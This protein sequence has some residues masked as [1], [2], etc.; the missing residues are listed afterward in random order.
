MKIAQ[1]FIAVVLVLAAAC[2]ALVVPAQARLT[3]IPLDDEY[4]IFVIDTSGS[5]RRYQW[6]RLLA[7]VRE[8]LDSYPTVRGIQVISDEGEHLLISF[9]GEWIRDTPT[10]RERILEELADWETFSTSNPRRGLLAALDR[11][12]DPAKSIALFVLGDDYS[13]GS[14]AIDVFVREVAARNGAGETGQRGMRI[15][16]FAFP[17][18][19]D[20][21]GEMGTGGDFAVLMSTLSQQ[22]GGGFVG[23]S[24]QRSRENA[25]ASSEPVTGLRAGGERVLVI[26]DASANMR[27]ASWQQAVDAAD[28]LLA[29]VGTGDFF[30]L[31]TLTDEARTVSPASANLWQSDADGS[32]RSE[33]VLNL[34]NM[35]PAGAVD[36]AAVAA[37]ISGLVPAPDSVYLLASGGSLVAPAEDWP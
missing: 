22:N 6:D 10:N 32:L 20:I 23:L 12:F 27:A 2:T 31:M 8:T 18:F 24:S 4:L 36:L 33:A 9:R 26:V 21:I 30:Q 1:S 5:M 28:W 11:Y 16:S 7:T 35:T 25:S 17:V 37:A 29:D 34:R 14:G 13:P 19:W 15:H 3:G